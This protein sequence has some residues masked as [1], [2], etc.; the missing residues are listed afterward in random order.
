MHLDHL[1]QW[2]R[3]SRWTLASFGRCFAD[4]GG[5]CNAGRNQCNGKPSAYGYRYEGTKKFELNRML[6]MIDISNDSVA[7]DFGSGKGRAIS[8][9]A[10]DSSIKKVYGVELSEQL[11]KISKENLRRLKVNNYE[12]LHVDARDI[13]DDILDEVN[14]IY[15]YNPFPKVVMSDVFKKIEESL[16][17]L[18]RMMMVIYFN[19]LHDEEL[20]GSSVFKLQTV[21]KNPISNSDFHIYVTRMA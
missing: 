4:I 15:L 3:S 10:L 5:S 19:P 12:V 9:L 11:V 21:I 8:C 17:R 18:P 2:E 20:V 1:N 7:I 14:L 6:N 13:P 16:V